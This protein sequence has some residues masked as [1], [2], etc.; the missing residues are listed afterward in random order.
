MPYVLFASLHFTSLHFALA[1]V[2][3]LGD[4]VVAGAIQTSIAK[5]PWLRERTTHDRIK[6]VLRKPEE[7]E[8]NGVRWT[9][10]FDQPR[11][12]DGK[13]DAKGQ[14]HDAQGTLA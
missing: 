5:T 8:K 7:A 11:S 10:L 12:V 2:L 13:C 3:N 6:R 14:G 4:M 9:A 1:K